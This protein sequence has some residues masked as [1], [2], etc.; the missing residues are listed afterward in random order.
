[1]NYRVWNVTP[2]SP[3][4]FATLQTQ[5]QLAHICHLAHLAPSSHNTQP[6]KY[7]I[8]AKHNT[9]DVYLDSSRILA[10]SDIVGRQAMISMGCALAHIHIAARYFGLSYTCKIIEHD[11]KTFLP[12]KNNTFPLIHIATFTFSQGGKNPTLA[13]LIDAMPKRKVM[14]AD[15][16]QHTPIPDEVLARIATISKEPA[17]ILHRITDPLRRMSI[18]EFQAQADGFV[19]NAKKFSRELGEWLLPNDTDS[20]I[21]MPGAGFG[22]QDEQALRLHEALLGKRNMEPEDGLRFSLAGKHGMEKSPFIG[23]LTVARDDPHHWL[24]T[25]KTMETMFLTFTAAGIQTAVH[26]GVVEVPLINRMFAASLG[27]TRRI[28]ALFRAGYIK[29]KKDL[30]RP[31]APRLPMKNVLLSARP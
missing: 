14:R 27:T 24:E 11:K 20:P 28:S 2:H 18:A 7:F 29:N 30:E 10:A 26:A 9:L 21:G 31:H 8:D 5:E 19:I 6:A 16:D 3:D 4:T 25:G 13:P 1:M 15:Y 23:F 17:I 22:L 12:R